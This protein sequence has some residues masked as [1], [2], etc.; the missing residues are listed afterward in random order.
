M[1]HIDTE[2]LVVGAG[3]AGSAA[4]VALGRHGIRTM[5]VSK[6]PW[7]ADSPRAHIVNQRTMEVLRA[8]G[9]EQACVDAASPGTDM[10]NHPMM[11]SLAG[12]EF[13]RLWT[14]G[15]D[16]VRAGEYGAASPTT[17]CDLPQDR[18]EPILVGEAM[19]LGVVTRYRTEFISLEQDEDG[20]TSVLRDLVTGKDFT[21]R[22]RFVVG[23]DGGQSPV[24]EA[25]G[26]PL[27]G[28]PGMGPAL[29]IHFKAD[30]TEYVGDRPGS[31]FW[32][33]QPG[34]EGAMGNAMLR[35]VRPWNEW[36]IGFVHLGES[37]RGASEQTLIELVHEVIGDDSVEVEIV[38]SYPW[39]IN[40]VLATEYG[41]GRVF[42]AGDAVH[43]HPPMNGL[44]GNTC[45][46]DGFNIAWK[47]AAVLRWGAARELLE[48]YDAER[49][50]VGRKV[51]D[52]AIAGWKQNP[53]VIRS[54]GIDPEAPAEVRQ[55]QFEVLF[56]DSDEGERRRTEFEHAKRSKAFSYHAHGTEMNQFYSSSAVLPDDSAPVEPARD[57]ELHFAMN[58]RPG[59]RLPH[60]W[61][62]RKG[63]TVSTL[64]LC[65]AEQFT[66]LARIRGRAWLEAAEEV[67]E[68]LGV[69][70][71]ALRIGPGCEAEDLYGV[72]RDESGIGESGCLLVRPDQ[73]IAWRV[74]HL[75]ED[76]AQ[77]LEAALRSVLS[78]AEAP[79]LR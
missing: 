26:L 21:V 25:I 50:P 17:G 7:V 16:P 77:Q 41:R 43:R 47:L 59:S 73:H 13:G 12:V 19:R 52:R 4:A 5:M 69:P 65:G 67:S 78:M 14:W 48:S 24:A 56:E 11:T 28:T 30:L 63:R 31:I 18:F 72:W 46:Q 44:G 49:R 27:E 74:E 62:R 15:N 54:L 8:L 6:A 79:T 51:V 36:I 55:A 3:L 39:R 58:S 10:A 75:A 2:V 23:A 70:I 35:M 9:L 34:R 38:G 66:L 64:D 53:E 33:F 60:A 37:I 40:H 32:I 57:I 61:V 1:E 29:N 22:S 68:K 20:V 45:I 42:C 76:P 71:A